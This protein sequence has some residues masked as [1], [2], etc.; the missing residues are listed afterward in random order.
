MDPIDNDALDTIPVIPSLQ[1]S[2]ASHLPLGFE[3][4]VGVGV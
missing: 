3:L 2:C 4:G 1:Q